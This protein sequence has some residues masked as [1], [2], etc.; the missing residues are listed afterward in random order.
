MYEIGIDIENIATNF[1]EKIN[2]ALSIFNTYFNST[3]PDV[4]SQI[5]HGTIK[6]YDNC[7]GTWVQNIE[8][9]NEEI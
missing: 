6:V 8:R 3:D 5:L 9:I 2:K 1:E 7:V 4:H